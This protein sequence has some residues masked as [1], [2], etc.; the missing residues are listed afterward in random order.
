[1]RYR[2]IKKTGIAVLVFLALFFLLSTNAFCGEQQLVKIGVLAKRG[3][4]IC[5]QKWSPTA[6]YL[7]SKVFG[8]KFIIVPLDYDEIYQ[9]VEK[10]EIDFVLANSSIY[11]E[12]ECWYGVI[13]IAS[14]KNKR[15]GASYIN[16]GG[17]IFFKANRTV[18]S[19][20]D[21]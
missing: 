11:V 17:T 5:L 15:I 6:E 1:M 9:A 12:L 8:C 4:K 13:R 18:F 20:A 14:L 3:T 19:V 2:F 21:E 10:G 16:Y 7:T